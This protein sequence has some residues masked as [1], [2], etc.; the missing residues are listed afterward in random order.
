MP[1]TGRRDA[2]AR[3]VLSAFAAG[4]AGSRMHTRVRW[5]TC[6]FPAI[7]ALVP[8]SGRVLDV[9]CGHGLLSIYLAATAPDRVVHAVDIDD[10]KVAVG[11][12]AARR[13]GVAERVTFEVVERG[14][15]P[16]AEHYDAVVANDVLY[17]MG[18]VH[19]GAFLTAAA[20]AIRPGGR[21]VVK[22]MAST[23]RWKASL[24]EAQELLATKVLRIT[25]GDTLEVL[26]EG[27]IEGPLLA[28]GLAV[29]LHR[30]D[31]G[32]PHP[33]LAVVGEHTVRT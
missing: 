30:L 9:G 8:T 21:V 2:T 23:P 12:D 16:R 28:A 14:W 31:R 3:R 1:G 17:L 32:Y 27:E 18:R 7:E 5:W 24:N 20:A 6:P 25:E 11:V 13:S 33:H 19:A 10:Q 15:R 26:M 29:T 4:G 22:E